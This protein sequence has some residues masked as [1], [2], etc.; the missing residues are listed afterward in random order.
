MEELYTKSIK[1]KIKSDVRLSLK[2]PVIAENKSPV[3]TS[4][5]SLNPYLFPASL[6][7]HFSCERVILEILL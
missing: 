4:E 1:K 3:L 2:E 6:L 7:S 5:I